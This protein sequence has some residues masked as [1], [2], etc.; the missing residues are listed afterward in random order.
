VFHT[1]EVQ[2]T[3]PWFGMLRR[4]VSYFVTQTHKSQ[5]KCQ[6]ANTACSTTSNIYHRIF[7]NMCKTNMSSK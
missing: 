7:E 3:R 2:I 4:G 1:K 6:T 5:R